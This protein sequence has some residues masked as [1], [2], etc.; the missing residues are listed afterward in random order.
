M[1]VL[2]ANDA[3]LMLAEKYETV[4]GIFNHSDDINRPLAVVALHPAENMASGSRLYE[5]MAAFSDY[6]VGTRFN[7]SF[8]DFMS[9]PR[10]VCDEMVRLSVKYQKKSLEIESDIEQQLNAAANPNKG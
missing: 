5:R 10:D 7:I 6:N 3:Q 9:C 4:Y 1:P 2:S 8:L